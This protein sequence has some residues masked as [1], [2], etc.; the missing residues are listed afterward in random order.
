M[1]EQFIGFRRRRARQVR[2][3]IDWLP[4]TS[5]FRIYKA[6]LNKYIIAPQNAMF[7]SESLFRDFMI[8][9]SF[10]QRIHAAKF[11]TGV[12]GADGVMV[13]HSSPGA[14]RA[15]LQLSAESSPSI[16]PSRRGTSSKDPGGIAL[17]EA[18]SM[19]EFPS[20]AQEK[21]HLAHRMMLIS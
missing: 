12:P 17:P 10:C 21:P 3:R 2:L 16:L 8:E 1:G 5:T 6:C 20:R 7:E 9:D 4:P 13:P 18:E 19:T 14:R 15:D 11:L